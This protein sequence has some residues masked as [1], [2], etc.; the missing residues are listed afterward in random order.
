MV[1]SYYKSCVFT[2]FLQ[3]TLFIRK[4]ETGQNKQPAQADITG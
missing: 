1:R 3:Y 2:G 4:Q